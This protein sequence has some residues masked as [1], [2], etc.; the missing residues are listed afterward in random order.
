MKCQEIHRKLIPL[1]LPYTCHGVRVRCCLNFFEG[2]F[3]KCPVTQSELNL[4]T[5]SSPQWGHC[6]ILV[7]EKIY[8][9]TSSRKC[10]ELPRYEIFQFP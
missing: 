2:N 3:M 7:T 8:F 10:H 6:W 4:Q 9:R 1:I 5:L